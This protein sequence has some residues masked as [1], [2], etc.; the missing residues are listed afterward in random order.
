MNPIIL[1]IFH[2][3]VVVPLFLFVG[4]QRAATPQWV[5]TILFGLGLFVLVYHGYFS[6]V[7]LHAKSEL[8]WKNLFH[9]ILIA[10]LLLWI[11]YHEKKTGKPF[12]ELMLI[13]GF[14]S[15]GYH[16][17]NIVFALKDSGS[18]KL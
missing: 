9:L 8:A 10:P 17:K 18:A 7:R 3:V 4:F 15:L 6:I 11:G 12:Y 13:A 2:L 1:G 16:L 5:Y 14:A